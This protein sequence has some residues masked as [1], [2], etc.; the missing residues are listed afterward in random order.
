VAPAHRHY[1]T[2][3]NRG[4]IQ[5]ITKVNDTTGPTW[6]IDIKIR[7]A[8]AYLRISAGPDFYYKFP[9]PGIG[10]GGEELHDTFGF[11]NGEEEVVIDC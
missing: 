2:L 7:A 11:D 1:G 10:D 9:Y 4:P 3:T 6:F 5:L 8:L